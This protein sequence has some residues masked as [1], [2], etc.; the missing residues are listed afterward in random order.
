MDIKRKTNKSVS[1][2]SNNK[3]NDSVLS[4]SDYSDQFNGGITLDLTK[5]TRRYDK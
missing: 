4:V 2:P 1:K 5:W 3:K